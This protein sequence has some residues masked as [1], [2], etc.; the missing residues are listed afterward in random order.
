[1]I[2]D[3]N[4]RLLEIISERLSNFTFIWGQTPRPTLDGLVALLFSCLLFSDHSILLHILMTTLA[5]ATYAF[6]KFL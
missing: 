1:M 6:E 4:N 3:Q 2:K 5:M